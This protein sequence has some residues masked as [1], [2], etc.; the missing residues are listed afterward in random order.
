MYPKEKKLHDGVFKNCSPT[1]WCIYTISAYQ[2]PGR[3]YYCC[4]PSFCIIDCESS[5]IRGRLKKKTFCRRRASQVVCCA[6]Y[7]YTGIPV[8]VVG[9]FAAVLLCWRLLLWIHRFCRFVLFQ[10]TT[11]KCACGCTHRYTVVVLTLTL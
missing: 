10:L 1:S 5:C 4:V 3:Q 8:V 7:R 11:N 2:V 6:V 9:G